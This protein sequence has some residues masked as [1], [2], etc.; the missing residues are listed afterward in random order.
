MKVEEFERLLT[1][2]SIM[3]DR[4]E[5]NYHKI[6]TAMKLILIS[7]K[8]SDD[9]WNKMNNDPYLFR[10]YCHRLGNDEYNI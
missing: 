5:N 9:I 8:L 4:I 2:L 7:N 3:R 1:R 10:I 6:N